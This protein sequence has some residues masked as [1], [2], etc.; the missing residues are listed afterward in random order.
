MGKPL[1]LFFVVGEA[2]GDL[3]A[4]NLI[5][6]LKKNKPDI[7]IEAW[8]GDLMEAQGARI[9]KHYREL[10]FMGFIEVVKNLRTILRNL[11]ICEKQILE[12]KPDAVVLVDYPGFN[13]RIAKKLKKQGIKVIYYISPQV[14][15]WKQSRVHKLK[16]VVDE[17]YVILPFEPA[18]YQK[19][20]MKVEFVGHPLLDA[21]QNFSATLQTREEFCS[22]YGLDPS[23]KIVA[24]LPGS[25]KQEIDV[26][27]PVMMKMPM[28]FPE[29]QFVIAGAPSVPD[30][31]YHRS[32]FDEK[33]II[34]RNKTY[35]LLSHSHA[36]MVTSGTATL[37]TALFGVPEVVC[38]KGSNISYQ[39]AKRLVKVKYISLVNLI[40]DEM[41]V[42]ELIQH[43][44]KEDKLQ[45]ELSRVL[46]DTDY[47]TRLMLGYELLR[48]KLGGAGASQHTASLLLKSM[49]Y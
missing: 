8:G 12:F 34:I 29:F 24:I 3:H 20:G 4:S 18:F 27:L 36:A 47:R 9:K 13:I 48:Q 19:F 44:F 38:Y 17:M 6:A 30:E 33:T 37:E 22:E 23:K 28:R 49:G 35:Q 16:E 1:K 11:D 14:W 32:I 2:S 40:M 39:I 25:R 41:L 45:F 31:W 26:K 43:D 7:E 15:A 42:T 46:I 5:H 21:I 10:A